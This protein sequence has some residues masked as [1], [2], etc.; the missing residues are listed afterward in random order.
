MSEGRWFRMQERSRGIVLLVVSVIGLGAEAI[1][2]IQDG[3]GAPKVIALACFGFLFWWG[4]EMARRR[5]PQ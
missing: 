2:T 4:W 3:I 5:P 1:S